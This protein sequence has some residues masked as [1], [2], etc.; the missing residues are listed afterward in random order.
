MLQDAV[1]AKQYMQQNREFQ[2][3]AKEWTQTY[4][5]KPSLTDPRVC[6]SVV[7]CFQPDSAPLGNCVVSTFCASGILAWHK[8]HDKYRC[9]VVSMQVQQ[10]LDMGFAYETVSQALLTSGGDSN[11]ALERLLGS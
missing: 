6:H 4:A 1:V 8:Q 2:R 5:V 3:Q 9:L 10:L 7:F 11:A